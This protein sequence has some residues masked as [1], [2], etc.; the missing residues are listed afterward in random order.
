MR[1]GEL[2]SSDDPTPRRLLHVGGA[3]DVRIAV[4]KDRGTRRNRSGDEG[5]ISRLFGE[6]EGAFRVRRTPLVDAAKEWIDQLEQDPKLEH[7]VVDMLERLLEQRR[8]GAPVNKAAA[9]G[10]ELKRARAEI[11][12]REGKNGL[13]Q[14]H[15]AGAPARDVEFGCIDRAPCALGRLRSRSEFERQFHEFRRR[16]WCGSRTGARRRLLQAAWPRPTLPPPLR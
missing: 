12:R 7:R 6:L 9:E 3:R 11:P 5:G 14:R 1:P 16:C 13:D 10:K 2:K 8:R 15:R 4:A